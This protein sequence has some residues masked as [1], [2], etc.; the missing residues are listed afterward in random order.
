MAALSQ[1]TGERTSAPAAST[2]TAAMDVS[3]AP[4]RESGPLVM[5]GAAA[6]IANDVRKELGLDDAS[7]PT[8][9]R[10]STADKAQARQPGAR[11]Q[12]AHDLNAL[13]EQRNKA[14]TDLRS[15]KEA[16]QTPTAAA[17]G[18]LYSSFS[19]VAFTA[20]TVAAKGLS[21]LTGSQLI[22]S[23]AEVAP[24]A[25]VGF[26]GAAIGLGALHYGQK[27]YRAMQK[28]SAVT[29]FHSSAEAYSAAYDKAH[30]RT[31]IFKL[32]QEK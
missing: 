15:W 16:S 23:M 19:A 29:D 1:N 24:V 30:P 26:A 8:L 9:T 2:P 13:R 4:A 22:H 31:N 14:E 6:S 7:S 10:S 27:I 25:A 21:A 11:E 17:F 3:N 32:A 18:F 5:G 28:S 20:A 12:V